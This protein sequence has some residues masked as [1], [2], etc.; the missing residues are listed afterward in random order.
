[1]SCSSGLNSITAAKSSAVLQRSSHSSLWRRLFWRQLPLTF[2]ANRLEPSASIL[3]SLYPPKAELS[4][5]LPNVRIRGT[6]RTI[7]GG[8]NSPFAA[9]ISF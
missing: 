6:K 7:G 3:R 5:P 2:C 1:M 9:V 8:I 4:F